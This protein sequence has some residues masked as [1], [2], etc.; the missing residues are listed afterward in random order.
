MSAPHRWI[1]AHA[2]HSPDAPALVY[3]GRSLS[4]A[5]LDRAV[6][7]L[8]ARL[9]EAGVG[10]GDRV[11]FLGQNHPAQIIQ[12]LACCR[13]GAIQ[14]PLNW[15]LAAPEHAFILADSGAK[16][17]MATADFAPAAQALG[18]PVLPAEAAWPAPGPVPETAEAG[19]AESIALLVYTSGTT[20][21]PKGAL[22]TQKALFFNALNAQHLFALTAADRVLTFLPL[23][24]VGG[25]NIQTLPALY[26]GA[27]VMLEPRFEPARFFA[28][29]RDF[30]PSLTL[31]VPAIMQALIGHPGWAEADLS[32]L[33]AAG[34]G[35]SD[36]PP[37]LIEAFHARGVPIQQIYGAT[38]TCPIA[39]GQT[40]AEALAAPGSVGRPAFHAMA[41]VVGP[42]GEDLPEG[43]TG[44]IAI[45]GPAI[46]TGYWNQPEASAQALRGGW[47]LTGD[48]GHK[49][50]A[51]RWWFTDRVK[52]VII[53]G[54]ENIYPAEVER[55]LA[56]AP[57]V[58]EGAVTGRADAHWGEVPVAVVVPEEGFSREAVLAHFQGKLAR[59]KHPRDVVLVGALPRTA[60]GKV[61][62]GALRALV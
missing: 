28:A 33:R 17:V 16:L 2:E 7:G 19:W 39:I 3:E 52:H 48:V 1:A 53:S 35:S 4:Y 47:F 54:G 41:K 12:L 32:S 30:R 22:L 55:V 40:R 15:R 44:Q 5:A 23:F 9:A 6:R 31:L 61:A 11:A 18:L 13:L 36:V 56:T 42:L 45:A 10:L 14:V 62:T 24:H 34:A 25:L 58:R 57:G 37:A 29:C 38:E 20:G 49:D 26:A 60:L 27:T 8:A 50:A 46:L 43:A 21:R 51:G 59:F